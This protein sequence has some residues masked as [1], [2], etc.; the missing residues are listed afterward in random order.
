VE[1]IRQKAYKKAFDT[2][3][4]DIS[5]G[6]LEDRCVK[7]GITDC[8]RQGEGHR[9]VVPFFDETIELVTPACTFKS[10]HGTSVSLVARIV[11]LHYLLHASGRDVGTELIG[12]D[13]IPGCRSYLP[14]FERRVV[15]PLLS[16][17]GY[18]RDAFMEAGKALGG[19]AEEYGSASVTVRVL[20]NVPL[21]FVLWEGDQDFPSSMKVLFDRSISEY[22]PLEDI[23]VI[24][25]MAST[26]MLAKARKACSNCWG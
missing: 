14:V 1:P 23:T 24:A 2:A 7:A 25:K 16:A 15:R 3:C 6:S 26:R 20:P 19:N 9:L 10:T 5:T 13:D 11:I 18:A 22:L 12:Y 21:T 8:H 4:R 17:F